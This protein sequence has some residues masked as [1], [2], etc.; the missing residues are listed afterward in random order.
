MAEKLRVGLIGANVSY[1]WSPR[2]HIPAHL[3]LTHSELAAV[4][5]A[6]PIR[7]PAQVHPK[8]GGRLPTRCTLRAR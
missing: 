5:T 7:L 6:Y 2:A 8:P 1:E 4:C 3:A